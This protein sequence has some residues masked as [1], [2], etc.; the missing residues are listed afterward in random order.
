MC[1]W[2]RYFFPHVDPYTLDPDLFATLWFEAEYLLAKTK[3]V[4][5]APPL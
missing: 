5:I 4:Q 2:I 1:A 3:P